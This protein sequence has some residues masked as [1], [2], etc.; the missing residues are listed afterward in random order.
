M[1]KMLFGV[2]SIRKNGVALVWLRQ[3]AKS[4]TLSEY[5]AQQCYKAFLIFLAVTT[6]Y[7]LLKHV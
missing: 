4:T 7:T 6:K 5:T 1:V 2:F 3:D